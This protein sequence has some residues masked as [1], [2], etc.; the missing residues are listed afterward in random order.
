MP[1]KCIGRN[2]VV[3][4]GP[5]FF[6]VFR[7]CK[8]SAL[9][10]GEGDTSAPSDEGL[11]PFVQLQAW[12]PTHAGYDAFAIPDGERADAFVRT[13]AERNDCECDKAP[14]IR[15]VHHAMV[16]IIMDMHYRFHGS[17]PTIFSKF[18][19]R[20][21]PKPG[22]GPVV[23]QEV[24]Q[25]VWKSWMIHAWPPNFRKAVWFKFSMEMQAATSKKIKADM[26]AAMT[27]FSIVG[28]EKHTHSTR[29]SV[30]VGDV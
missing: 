3:C 11:V 26:A 12:I 1:A 15:S 8:V 4:V 7:A 17:R 24:I 9:S 21:D 25:S 29:D 5:T 18:I 27:T 14:K 10:T 22:D 19:V 30:V 2:A 28:Y 6:I 16:K 23:P 20:T 13:F